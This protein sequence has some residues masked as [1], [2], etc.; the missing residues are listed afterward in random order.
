MNHVRIRFVMAGMDCCVWPANSSYLEN[1]LQ[2]FR[3]ILTMS[4]LHA[5]HMQLP[6]S[7]QQTANTA[8]LKHRTR[9]QHFLL[10][11][12]LDPTNEI[13]LIFDKSGLQSDGPGANSKDKRKAT[14]PCHLVTADCHPSNS[15]MSS[16]V[17]EAGTIGPCPLIRCSDMLGY[18][19]DCRPGPAARIEQSLACNIFHSTRGCFVFNALC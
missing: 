14:H 2:T 7:Q 3:S 18:D 15:W 1:C 4:P 8:L 6:I 12:K 5:G 16:A 13:T 19:P 17:P 11:S 10:E 9:L